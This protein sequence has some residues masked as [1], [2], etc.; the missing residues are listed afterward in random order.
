M[1]TEARLAL[2]RR[3]AAGSRRVR[4]WATLS[5]ALMFA[6]AIVVWQT[7][8][9]EAVAIAGFAVAALNVAAYNHGRAD[10]MDRAAEL[11][12]DSQKGSTP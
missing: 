7:S 11:L 8:H 6:A 2:L 9:A 1:R 3:W 5:A 10:G 4:L 12:T